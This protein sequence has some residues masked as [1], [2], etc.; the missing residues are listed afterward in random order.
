MTE[1]LRPAGGANADAVL[2]DAV[3][4]DGSL[5]SDAFDADQAEGLVESISPGRMAF[6]RFRRHKLA[7]GS[8]IVFGLIALIVILAPITTRYS[9]IQRL[10]DIGGKATNNPPS[11]KAWFGTDSLN[12]DLYSR[13]IW[14][15]RVSL[16]IGV[17]VA[18]VSSILGTAVGAIAGLAVGS[19]TTC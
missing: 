13:I 4:P 10:P 1:T 8:V 12:R 16:L 15:G 7:V 19:S 6:R 2:P 3:L 9:A 11:A 17:A 5:P 18:I 14:G